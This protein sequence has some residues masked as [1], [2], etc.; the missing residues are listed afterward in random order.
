MI[1]L[2]DTYTKRTTSEVQKYQHIYRKPAK[3]IFEKVK[4]RSIMK[5]MTCSLDNKVREMKKAYWKQ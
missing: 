4:S 1:V 2:I 5:T 3:H